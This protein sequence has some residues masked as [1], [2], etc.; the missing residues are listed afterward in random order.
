MRRGQQ[1]ARQGDAQRISVLGRKACNAPDQRD[2]SL[3]QDD[4]ADVLHLH[5]P[6]AKS[7]GAQRRLGNETGHPSYHQEPAKN[8]TN[9]Q[10]HN[11]Q[12]GRHAGSS[13]VELRRIHSY[14]SR[15]DTTGKAIS[16][17]LPS[18]V[19][20]DAQRRLAYRR[21]HDKAAQAHVSR[22]AGRPH[23]SAAPHDE[24]VVAA[25]ASTVLEQ[26]KGGVPQ[27][28]RRCSAA[29]ICFACA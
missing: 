22:W 10:Q 3:Q 24:L 1:I 11:E 12:H 29:V 14:Q 2:A 26:S 4:A 28:K 20:Q 17:H 19:A 27:S 5:L 23:A 7:C 6:S 18:K 16:L 21:M 13:P 9:D 15:A 8:C 25:P